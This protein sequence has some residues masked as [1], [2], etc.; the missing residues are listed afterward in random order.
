MKNYKTKFVKGTKT[1]LKGLWAR[2]RYY[3]MVRTYKTKTNGTRLYSK[4]WSNKKSKKTKK[5]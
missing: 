5:W 4:K 2:T 3:V 1:T